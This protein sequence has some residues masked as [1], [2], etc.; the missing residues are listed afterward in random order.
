VLASFVLGGTA[1]A[2]VFDRPADER[3]ALEPFEPAAPPGP[4]LQLPPAPPAPPQRPPVRTGLQVFVRE[5]RVEGSTVYSAEELD[6][7]TRPWTNRELDAS[8]IRDLVDAVTQKYVEDGYVSSGAFLPDQDLEG[9]VLIVKA[10]EAMLADVI[11]EGNRWYRTGFLRRRLQA[12]VPA[13][14][15]VGTLQEQIQLLLQEQGIRHIGAALQPG[16]RPGENVLALNV[17]ERIPIG[18]ETSTAN[19][20]PPGVG[21][22]AGQLD[23]ADWSLFGI[24][25][26]LAARF[27]LSEGLIS[28]EV[29]YDLPFTPRGTTLELRF[30]NADSEIVESPFDAADI[31]AD[32]W[33]A[34]V[35]LRVPVIRTPRMQLWTGVRGE[36]RRSTTYLAGERES[37]VPGPEDGVAEVNVLRFVSDWSWRSRT[38]AVS[39]RSTLS[40]GIGA[41]GD[42]D[43]TENRGD[44]PDSRYV[45]WL[46]QLQWAHR[47]PEWAWGT[48]LLARA[49][50]QLADDPLLSIE[51]IAMGGVGTVRGYREN[52]LVRDQGVIASLELRIPLL[53]PFSEGEIAGFRLALAPFADFGYA[54]NVGH[55]P[56]VQ[57]LASLGLGLRWSWRDRIEGYAYWG[58]R[59]RSVPRTDSN[60][61]DDGFHL[62]IR[63][64][65]F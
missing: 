38:D 54:W 26:V 40:W 46:G 34:A 65:V 45:A 33:T 60:I 64:R 22:V 18:V 14:V 10:V 31:E 12:M 25:D 49:D 21:P 62:G 15:D 37:F 11:A 30:R 44:V 35:G 39:A 48:T 3:P 6:E 29:R 17:E 5:V 55:T 20:S 36:H 8:E 27:E 4:A 52:L 7:L 61:Q 58:G 16:A 1:S 63:V 50:L 47:F 51:Q 13:P 28:E 57:T 9:G 19:D 43:A 42:L 24:G 2:Q 56:P 59:L 41:L 32:T 23:L 53:H